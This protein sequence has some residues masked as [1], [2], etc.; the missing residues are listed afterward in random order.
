[1][2]ESKVIIQPL[3]K[4]WHGPHVSGMDMLRLDLLDPVISGNK[5]YKLK[6]NLQYAM[7]QGY[8]SILT[9]GGAFSNHLIATAAAAQLHHIPAVGIVRGDD[10]RELTATLKACREY[11]M[12]LHFVTREE[13]KH[14]DEEDWLARLAAKFDKPF[15]IPEGGANEQ[16][17][18]GAAEIAA[19]IPG[20]YTHI[21]VSLGTGTT[22]IGLRNAL[23]VHQQLLGFV[24]MKNGT[25][26]KNEIW[27][28]IEQDQDQNW[29]LY[30][31]WHFGGFGK[32]TGELIS[33]MNGFY[34]VNHIPLDMV[35]TAK[36]MYGLK[37]LLSE[38]YFPAGANILCIHTGGLQGN[39][40]IAAELDYKSGI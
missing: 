37:D 8:K 6:H 18:A 27:M 11:G 25:Y 26:L 16:G 2:D 35:Y 1:M 9:F 22:F 33:F 36:M 12:Q 17:R 32:W 5:W 24:P 20:S 40:A 15:I 34:Q 10:G 21:C 23:P 29:E 31:R 19:L 7:Q 38:G 30:D 14:K 3:D 4:E 39:A 28:A 13:Y